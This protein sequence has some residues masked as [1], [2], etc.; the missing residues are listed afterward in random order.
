M[1]ISKTNGKTSKKREAH[2]K[3]Q[4]DPDSVPS[5]LEALAVGESLAFGGRIE[6][7]EFTQAAAKEWLDKKTRAMSV[8]VSRAKESNP[9]R[10]WTMERSVALAFTSPYALAAL[11][12][13]R[14]K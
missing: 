10:E 5:Q 1:A 14:T 6:L 2:N 8:A 3:G 4:R 7:D 13:T 9:T 11:L 12:I